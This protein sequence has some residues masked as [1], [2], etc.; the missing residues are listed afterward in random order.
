MSVETNI[1]NKSS[2]KQDRKFLLQGARG[3]VSLLFIFSGLIKANDP[4]G[5][6]YKLQ[7]Y[8]EVFHITFL[9]D[10]A[11][12]I[13]ILLCTLE[14]VL[15]ALLFLGI[16][17]KQVAW[18]LLIII[19]FFTFLTFYSAYF[20]V[21]TSCGC[22]GD[23]IKLTP[24][25]SF[26]KDLVL[27]AL[28]LI[29]FVQRNY[30]KPLIKSTVTQDRTAIGIV[31]FSLGFGLYTYNYLPI[32]DFLPYKVGNNIPALMKMPLGAPQD[33]YEIMYNLK[34]K[35]TGEVKK[36]TD[37][38]YLKTGIWKDENWEIIGDPVNKLVKEGFQVKIK[39]LKIE[40]AQGTDYTNEII[41]NPY[42]NL[43]IVA[44][45]LDHTNA[46][47]IGDLNAIAMNAAE[48]YNIRTVL[49]TSNSAE[50]VTAFT[51]ANKLVMEVFYADAIPL[52]SMVR[53]NP[54]VMLLKNGIVINKW[55]YHTV[56]TYDELAKKYFEKNQ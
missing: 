1:E 20:E 47:A 18:G 24:W 19:I 50:D 7:E 6:G 56:P 16:R 39:D 43:V 25:Q 51:K 13:A 28:I 46:K 11:T 4:L 2:F 42:Y 44:Y 32:L 41:G 21:V 35:K 54:G 49:I 12:A 31:L 37:K 23:A 48:N 22:F 10:Y 38:E 8:F 33:V 36:M 34:N 5:F 14:I 53:A 26:T 30:I 9:H 27:L 45:N 17:G 3:L 29:I 55:H 15:G 40:D 52:K